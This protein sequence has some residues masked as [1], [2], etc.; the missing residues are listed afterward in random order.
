MPLVSSL[1]LLPSFSEYGQNNQSYQVSEGM[2]CTV[3]HNY[4]YYYYENYSG[5]YKETHCWIVSKDRDQR[6]KK[7]LYSMILLHFVLTNLFC[8]KEALRRSSLD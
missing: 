8:H 1:I 2:V 3:L 6:I 5:N 4:C 7:I